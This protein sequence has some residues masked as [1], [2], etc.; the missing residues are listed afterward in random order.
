V[1]PR[2]VAATGC[3]TWPTVTPYFLMF[4]FPVLGSPLPPPFFISCV[5]F[6]CGAF[7]V[8]IFP[9]AFPSTFLR[10]LTTNRLPFVDVNIFRFVFHLTVLAVARAV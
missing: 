6:Y 3:E 5:F 9:V 2:T 4:V 10:Y 8:F 7:C 1:L